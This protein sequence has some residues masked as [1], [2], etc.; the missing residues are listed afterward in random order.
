MYY[1][2]SCGIRL[3]LVW[4]L[5]KMLRR[6]KRRFSLI[7]NLD[8]RE[9]VS[10][11][12]M[13]DL[14][15]LGAW[16]LPRHAEVTFSRYYRQYRLASEAAP[17]GTRRAVTMHVWDNRSLS[18]LSRQPT[19]GQMKVTGTKYKGYIPNCMEARLRPCRI[20]R[21]KANNNRQCYT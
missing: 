13:V 20:F 11:L 18:M 3:T 17:R 9:L 7:S 5:L 21:K 19:R 6:E 14:S 4:A 12:L 1:V 2:L 15:A 16:G 8:F 10:G